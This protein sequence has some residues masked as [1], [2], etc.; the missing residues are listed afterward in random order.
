V[1][2][3]P[4]FGA[5]VTSVAWNR[6]RNAHVFRSHHKQEMDMRTVAV[7]ASVLAL[8]ACSGEPKVVSET[9]GSATSG[10]GVTYKYDGDQIKEAS[11][12]AAVYCSRYGK[13]AQLRSTSRQSGDNLATFDCR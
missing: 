6:C 8:A 9:S 3:K 10:G 1:E 12:K 11:E 2:S 7:I 5:T 13:Q 4:S